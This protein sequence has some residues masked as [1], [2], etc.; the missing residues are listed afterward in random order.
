MSQ[1]VK[2]LCV[3]IAI[4]H[5]FNPGQCGDAVGSGFGARQSDVLSR[6]C[7]LFQC[8][9]SIYNL[10]R[11]VVD[12][13]LLIRNHSVEAYKSSSCAGSIIDRIDFEVII[14]VYQDF[15]L[16]EV[17]SLFP[18][19]KIVDCSSD[20][21]APNQL[22]I[23]ARD[24]LLKSQPVAG[25]S[26]YMEDDLVIH[27]SL[28]FDKLVLFFGAFGHQYVLMPHRY[29]VDQRI[30][31]HSRLY[32]DGP[33]D[34]SAY[35]TWHQPELNHAMWKIPSL[36]DCE[37]SLDAPEN[38]H[39]GFFA[40]SVQQVSELLDNRHQWPRDGFISPLETAATYT[41]GKFFKILKVSMEYQNFFCVEHSCP[42]YLAY[43]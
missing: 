39:A 22:G 9:R 15:F 33:I 16:G 23:A 29:E 21:S 37:I 1:P 42:S 10:R 34:A 36:I 19:V 31:L 27:D 17:L 38:P 25:L 13:Q 28:F 8:L 18:F 40:V 6:S 11:S 35:R 43:I 20:I 14:C 30:N 24:L 4:P 5:F 3:R 32:V 12:S 41:V 2:H 26:V 7:S